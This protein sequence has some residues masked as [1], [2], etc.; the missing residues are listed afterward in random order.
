MKEIDRKL[1]VSL[2]RDNKY[3]N[4]YYVLCDGNYQND[5]YADNDSDA[6]NIFR[7][8]DYK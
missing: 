4:H 5:F 7:K 2:H 1:F 3:P 8:G 6:I